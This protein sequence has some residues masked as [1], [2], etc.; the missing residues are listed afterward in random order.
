MIHDSL[1]FTPSSI[2]PLTLRNRTIRAAAFEGMCIANGPSDALYRYHTS[3]AAGEIGMTTVAYAA[4]NRSGLSFPTQLWMRPEIVPG[5]KHLTDGIHKEGAAASIQ[6]G[7]CGNMSHRNICGCTP[8]SASSGFNMYSP[9]FV[10]AMKKSEILDMVKDFGKATELAYESGFDAVEIHAGHGYLLSQFMSTWLNKRKDEYGGSFVNRLRFTSQVMEEVMEVAARRKMAVLVKMNMRDGFRGGMELD[11]SLQVA[12]LLEKAGA[13]A[14]V[15]SGGYVSRAPM[16][17]MRGAMPIKTLTYYMPWNYVK[18]GVG[19]IGKWMIPPVPFKEG[20][21]LEDAR[22]FRKHIRIPLVCL[23]GMFSRSV[24]EQ[25]LDGGFEFIGLARPLINDPAFVKHMKEAEE[26]DP[27]CAFSS[28][29]KHT[30][31]C[32]ARMYSIDMACHQHLD[33]IPKKL[34]NELK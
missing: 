11:E 26:K 16:Y 34:L 32:I 10:R 20:Y 29:C 25:A 9:T 30:N 22:I 7:H 17:V 21:F 2:G 33:G 14:L 23:G 1:L 24:I 6:M 3:V 28:S 13:H 8:V 19:M 15:L 27:G 31:Y 18:I 4:V 5:L 12:A